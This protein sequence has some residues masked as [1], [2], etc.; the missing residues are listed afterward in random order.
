MTGWRYASGAAFAL[1]TAATSTAA[2][3]GKCEMNTGSPFQLR[4]AEIYMSKLNSGKPGE[5]EKHAQNTVEVLTKDAEKIN[6][7]AGRNYLL[8]RILAWWAARPDVD[9]VVRRG[10]IGYVTEPDASID[11]AAAIDTALDAVDR[12]MPEC[13]SR[14][15]TVRRQVW[16]GQINAAS[17]NLNDDL[18]DS[19][20]VYLDR[21]DVLLGNSAYNAYFRAVLAQ[22][23]G[24]PAAELFHKAY[25]AATE[26]AKTDSNAAQIRRQSLYNA[27]VL[28]LE[29]ASAADESARGPMMKTAAQRF[30]EFLKE[31]PNSPQASTVQGA[32]ARSLAASGDTAA[33]VGMFAKMIAEP[34]TYS[35]LQLF[36]ASVAAV[37]ADRHDDAIRLIELGLERNPYYRDAIFNLAT[38]YHRKKEYEKMMPLAQQLLELD[39]NNPDNYRIYAG[40]LQGPAERYKVE[41]E[42]LQKERGKKAQFDATMKKLQTQNDSVLKYVQLSQES[43][44]SVKVQNMQTAGS[45]TTLTGTVENRSESP[46]TFDLKFEFLDAQGNVVA[47]ESATVQTD[48]KGAGTFRVE[49]AAP[50][51]VA[52]RYAPVI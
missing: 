46:K 38:L 25:V 48:A 21:A 19:A 26:E 45:T 12:S 35:P 11:L 44:V 4:S 1:L 5:V 9:F 10:E 22:K 28:M 31:Y 33:A 52:W 16:T 15:D 13:A 34:N 49:A 2:A 39:P 40:A 36:E 41:A 30:E 43:P 47:S 32:L 37:R 23:K 27:G 6:N 8:A 7:V 18:L 24:Q 17:K 50:G 20:E 42:A 51:V 29:Q 14:A 3:Q